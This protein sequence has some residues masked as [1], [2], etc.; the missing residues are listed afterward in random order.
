M[1]EMLTK[2]TENCIVVDADYVD[3]VAFN[4]TVNFERM[5]ERRIKEA[6]LGKWLEC[7][8]LDGGLRPG[9]HQTTVVLIHE[10]GRKGLKYFAPSAYNDL[11]GKA[12]RGPLGEFAIHAV[13]VEEITTKDDMVAGIAEF[14]MQQQGVKRLLVVPDAEEGSVVQRLRQT[15]RQAPDG[16]QLTLFAM[17]P[18][19]GGN[20]R[21]EI[22]GYS[23]LH[24]LGIKG[25]E[26]GT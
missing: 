22:L 11:N 25:E 9:E 6:D 2:W 13:P 18:L 3:R 21:S 12:F 17:S 1:N 8:A 7:L 10:K 19:S 20:F 5:L 14:L 16:L 23:L 15:A 26:I 4:L 24:A